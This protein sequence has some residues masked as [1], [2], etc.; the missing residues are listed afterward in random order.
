VNADQCTTVVE[1]CVPR[2]F[3]GASVIGGLVI[4]FLL[5]A[6]LFGHAL[7]A[8]RHDARDA[9]QIADRRATTI[10]RLERRVVAE[11]A[12][13]RDAEEKLAALAPVIELERHLRP[14]PPAAGTTRRRRR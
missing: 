2:G 6:W 1:A 10:T 9:R 12:R 13:A 11:Q 8:A 7:N 4:G 3:A 14:V 5:A